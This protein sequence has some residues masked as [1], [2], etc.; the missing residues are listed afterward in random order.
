MTIALERT[1]QPNLIFDGEMIASE[2]GEDA[3]QKPPR[4]R[5]HEVGLFRTRSGKMVASIIYRTRW[6]EEEDYAIASV[7]DEDEIGEF[8]SQHDPCAHVLGYPP[9]DRYREKQA[10]LLA[11][12]RARY[13]G[14]VSKLLQEAKI[15]EVIE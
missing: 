11:D 2:S 8:F 4:W 3:K 10:R 13:L 5:W 7:I 12:I 15:G 6:E 14:L 1:G 9:N